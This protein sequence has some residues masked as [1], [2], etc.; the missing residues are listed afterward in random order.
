ML[1]ADEEEVDFEG[2]LRILRADSMN[3]LDQFEARLPRPASQDALAAMAT[4]P[5]GS[6]PH[7]TSLPSV[8]EES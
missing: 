1:C 3:S 5:P 6:L 4:S 2:F 8:A 7:I